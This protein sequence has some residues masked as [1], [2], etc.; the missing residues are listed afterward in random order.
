MRKNSDST[1]F[2]GASSHRKII[3]ITGPTL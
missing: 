1:L 2:Q 3:N